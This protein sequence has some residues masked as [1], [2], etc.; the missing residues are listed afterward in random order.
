[1]LDELFAE[2]TLAE[3]EE[4]LSRQQGQWDV[5]LKAGRVR[6][7]EQVLA[8]E[9]AQLVEHDDDGKVVLVPAPA[10]FGGEVTRL[11]RGPAL[12]ADTDDVLAELGLDTATIADLRE[13]S[14]R[15]AC[16]NR[17]IMRK[18]DNGPRPVVAWGAGARSKGVP[19]CNAVRRRREHVGAGM[20]RSRSGDDREES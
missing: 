17:I 2:R 14:E 10:Q 13:R 12:G 9:Y 16:G 6:Y 5:F 4:V 8:N 18:V 19:G 15:S 1:M 7:D 20:E 3:W 11:G